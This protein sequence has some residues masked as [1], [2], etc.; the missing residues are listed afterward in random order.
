M[1]KKEIMVLMILNR[2]YKITDRTDN[3]KISHIK[4]FLNIE[5]STR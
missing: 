3:D 2:L 1:L 5:E 4:V